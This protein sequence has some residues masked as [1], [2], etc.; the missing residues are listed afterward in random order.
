M[1]K[2]S[3]ISKLDRAFD[4]L[5]DASDSLLVASI[6]L[7]QTGNEALSAEAKM[8]S[9]A[10]T[11]RVKAIKSIRQEAENERQTEQEDRNY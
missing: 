8:I 9:L 5:A 4:C 1:P 11:N 6:Y 3:K 2:M 10:L 7:E